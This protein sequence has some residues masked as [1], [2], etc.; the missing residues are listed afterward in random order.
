MRLHAIIPALDEAETIAS[1]VAAVSRESVDHIIVVDNG[2]SDATAAIAAEA[3]A[4]VVVEPER[5]YGAACLA[6]LD[7][8]LDAD[9]DDVVV[10]IDGDG[11]SDPK[12]IA[13]LVTPIASGDADLVIGSRAR[14]AEAGSL[15]VV[16]RFGNWLATRLLDR[17]YGTSATDLGPTR[18]IRLAALRK[19][20]MRD[21]GFGWTM[22][23]QV[24][25]A[26][27]GLRVR[28]MPVRYRRRAAG[29]SKISGTLVGSA[30][31]GVTILWTLHSAR[32][33]R[34]NR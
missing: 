11:Q 26:I 23:M 5:G 21:R 34:G 24:R 27:I 32:R 14:G 30:R 20:Q 19:L 31:A 22:E 10:F 28:E 4:D 18:A 25:A 7:V 16:Q 12:D 2:S 17:F 1:V 9:D 3:G 29:K 6:G 33:P 13:S 15:S 8:L